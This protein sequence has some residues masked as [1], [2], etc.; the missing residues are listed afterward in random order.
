MYAVSFLSGPMGSS[1]KVYGDKSTSSRTTCEY[2]GTQLIL[3]RVISASPQILEFDD[4]IAY[5]AS[6]RPIPINQ[7]QA[8]L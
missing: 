3:F 1:V 5:H 4:N 6:Q 2:P 7:R 8:D